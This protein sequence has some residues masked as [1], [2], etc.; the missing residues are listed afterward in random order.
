MATVLSG[1]GQVT[2]PPV[3]IPESLQH[4]VAFDDGVL[5]VAHDYMYDSRVDDF[6]NRLRRLGMLSHKQGVAI[7]AIEQMATSKRRGALAMRDPNDVMRDAMDFT[8]KAITNKAS[9]VHFTLGRT[10]ARVEYRIDGYLRHII[11]VPAKYATAIINAIYAHCEGVNNAEWKPKQINSGRFINPAY[12]SEGLYA[13][14][15]A[16]TGLVDGSLVV[17]RLLYETIGSRGMEKQKITLEDLG[18]SKK[19]IELL[20]RMGREPNGLVVI[21]GPTGAGKSTSLKYLMEYLHQ[22]YPYMNILTVEDPPEYP[23]DGG[24]QIPVQTQEDD[25]VGQE[26]R[27]RAFAMT[28]ASTLRL[29]PDIVMVGEI[30]DGASAI[31]ALRMAETGHRV[32]TTLHANDAWEILTR[33]CD[34]LVEADMSNPLTVLANTQ[35]TTGIMAQRL[36]PKLCEHCKLSLEGHEDRISQELYAHLAGVMLNFDPKTIY[37]KG[38]GCPKCVEHAHGDPKLI[39]ADAGRGIRG[40]TLVCEI[41]APDQRLLDI[42]RTQ[43]V[44]AARRFWL[45]RRD[46][47]TL[48]DHALQKIAEGILAPDVA[49]EFVGPLISSRMEI[50][51]LSAADQD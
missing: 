21:S 26:Q 38:D 14:R 19:Q 17:L 48:V 47:E 35:N 27:N 4:I 45:E 37:V 20:M 9:D 2:A 22:E 12:L 44:P 43:G 51:A 1:S 50:A 11:D 3:E 24:K 6:E 16:S 49:V 34:L 28:I 42:V 32:W 8:K 10:S 46:G 39:A 23:I 25:T 30:R 41:V 18:F 31:A 29:D 15:F 40:R 7:A 33:M 13:I 5:Y 36:I